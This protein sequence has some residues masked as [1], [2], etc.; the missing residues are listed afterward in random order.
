MQ[1]NYGL[2]ADCEQF[3]NQ[4]TDI[5][6]FSYSYKVLV[7]NMFIALYDLESKN[8]DKMLKIVG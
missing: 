4:D 8:T 2:K 1:I 7:A 3:W 5:A 6:S